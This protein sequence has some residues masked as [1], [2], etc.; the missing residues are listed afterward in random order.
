MHLLKFWIFSFIACYA[1]ANFLIQGNLLICIWVMYT[2][3]DML[4]VQKQ[5][6]SNFNL[7]NQIACGGI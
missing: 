1:F 6:H 7:E 2:K 5:W 3:P 4:I